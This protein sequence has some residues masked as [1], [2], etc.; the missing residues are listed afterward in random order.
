MHLSQWTSGKF[1]GCHLF[2]LDP[3]HNAGKDD[4][5]PD[6]SALP[7]NSKNKAAEMFGRGDL[8]LTAAIRLKAGL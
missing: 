5:L 2:K 1:Y 3:L 7:F 8:R 4:G 6:L